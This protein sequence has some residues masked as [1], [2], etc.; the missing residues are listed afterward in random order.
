MD[1]YDVP[2]SGIRMR[3]YGAGGPGPNGRERHNDQRH[4]NCSGAAALL[5]RASDQSGAS[6][7]TVDLHRG[8]GE[9]RRQRER[10]SPLTILTATVG[11]ADP[12]VFVID[13]ANH[14]AAIDTETGRV[15][16]LNGSGTSSGHI[17][18]VFFTGLGSLTNPP[19]DGAACLAANPVPA[20]VTVTATIGGESAPVSYAGCAPFFAG[21]NQ[22]NVTVPDGL[23]ES[24]Q[25]LV[26]TVTTTEGSVSSSATMIPVGSSNGNNAED[27][28]RHRAIAE[29][30]LFSKLSAEY[31]I[32]RDFRQSGKF[33]QDRFFR[34]HRSGSSRLLFEY[35]KV[36]VLQVLSGLGTFFRRT[37]HPDARRAALS[38]LLFSNN[39]DLVPFS[40]LAGAEHQLRT[41]K[42]AIHDVGLVFYPVVGHLRLAVVAD[43]EQHGHFAMLHFRPHLD[44][45]FR[46]VVV[47][48]HGP[49]LL[50]LAG[51]TVCEVQILD[52]DHRRKRLVLRLLLPL[53]T[54]TLLRRTLLPSA[55]VV[56][57]RVGEGNPRH[58]LLGTRHQPDVVGPPVCGNQE[59]RIEPC[60]LR[61]Q[62]DQRSRVRASAVHRR[63]DV[64][65][66][67]IA[68]L[69]LTDDPFAGLKLDDAHPQRGAHPVGSPAPKE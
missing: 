43:H 33:A 51:H 38:P 32:N 4:G 21:L 62:H 68:D 37:A 30:I 48:A 61:L 46:T 34:D 36:S 54:R 14:A 20:T 15:L 23:A 29:E 41:I 24:D 13:A 3:G 55:L 59:I 66:N 31:G 12:G 53:C 9:Y 40:F 7:G 44:I 8:I 56:V 60:H 26:M 49:E 16:G 1:R 6:V 27:A 2:A 65:A 47:H 22:A 52:S 64:P 19:P 18:E 10:A 28:I 63:S 57:V 11:T 25:P 50:V 5:R 58:V 45:G 39:L 17:L 69:W 67:G 42:Q 35:G